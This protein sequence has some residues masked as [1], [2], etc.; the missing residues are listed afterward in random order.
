MIGIA[1]ESVER[2]VGGQ[3]SGGRDSPL[4]GVSLIRLGKSVLPVCNQTIKDQ[5]VL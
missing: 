5:Q 2:F 3:V 1:T 4:S